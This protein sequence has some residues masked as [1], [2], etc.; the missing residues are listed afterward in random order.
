M[1]NGIGRANNMAWV[2]IVEPESAAAPL[3][4]LYEKATRRAGKIPNIA[5]VQSLR[6]T[7][8]MRGFDLYCQLMDDP[9]GLS[10]RERVLIAT[11]VSKVNGCYYWMK[12]H[13]NDLRS[14][15]GDET[16][17]LTV[18]H[19]YRLADLLPQEFALLD[20]AVK[21]TKSPHAVTQ[22]DLQLLRDQGYCDEKIVDAVQCIGYFNF[23]NRVLDGL[24]VDPEPGMRYAESHSQW[25]RISIGRI[26]ATVAAI[27]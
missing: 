24:G 9:T 14:A 5:R 20:Y 2:G 25:K 3:G 12:S 7:T 11:V 21:L 4:E 18:Q 6:P 13:E 16:A 26:H 1:W 8:A 23:I 17:V 15:V 19:D 27:K 22:A 10:K